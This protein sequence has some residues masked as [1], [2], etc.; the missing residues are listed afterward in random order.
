M[1]RVDDST[2][3]L[4]RVLAAQESA[5]ISL[6]AEELATAAV[7]VPAKVAIFKQAQTAIQLVIAQSHLQ[8]W[9]LASTQLIQN[10]SLSWSL[11]LY[12]L[13]FFLYFFLR[14]YRQLNGD[15]C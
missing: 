1:L 10:I 2:A 14:I 7:T 3:E 8:V 12:F 9:E 11:L 4:L 5:R 15:L 13:S 6:R